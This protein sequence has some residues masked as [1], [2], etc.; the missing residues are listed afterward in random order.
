MKSFRLFGRSTSNIFLF[1]VL[2]LIVCSTAKACL[3]RFNIPDPGKPELYDS[4]F[5]AKVESFKFVPSIFSRSDITPPY[6]IV[7]SESIKIL[8]GDE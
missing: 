1:F 4:I 3:A 7:L 2:Y 8:Y 6:E 5:I